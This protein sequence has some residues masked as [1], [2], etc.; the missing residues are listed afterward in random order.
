MAALCLRNV[1]GGKFYEPEPEPG[2]IYVGAEGGFRSPPLAVLSFLLS[3]A[4]AILDFARATNGDL[5]RHS[6]GPSSSP[7]FHHLSG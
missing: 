7:S 4:G 3:R 6:R 1:S 5:E 2:G